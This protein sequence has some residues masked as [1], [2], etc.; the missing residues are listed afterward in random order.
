MGGKVNIHYV[1]Y[2]N[3][4]IREDITLF[5]PTSL[6]NTINKIYYNY[7]NFKD[8][9]IKNIMITVLIFLF[10][11]C[12]ELTRYTTNQKII[13]DFEKHC[14]VKFK[15]IEKNDKNL[16][17]YS[18]NK[19]FFEHMGNIIVLGARSNYDEYTTQPEK[20]DNIL[21]KIICDIDIL[22]KIQIS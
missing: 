14:F 20:D 3:K 9:E 18:N 22:E 11:E 17:K 13:Y 5:K 4:Y 15:Y 1:Y 12:N 19:R 2:R 6:F 21:E 10:R 8:N 7:G 16:L